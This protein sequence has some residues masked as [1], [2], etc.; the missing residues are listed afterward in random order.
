MIVLKCKM[1]GGN[2][3]V[4]EAGSV[5]TCPAC[6]AYQTVTQTPKLASQILFNRACELRIKGDFERAEA[7]YKRLAAED[8]T[9]AEAY[10]GIVLSKYGVVYQKNQ[11]NGNWLPMVQKTNETS[12]YTDADYCAAIERADA[13]KKACYEREAW[14][15]DCQEKNLLGEV[16]T[17]APCDVFLLCKTSDDGVGQW[18]RDRGLANRI[19]QNLIDAGLQVYYAPAYEAKGQRVPTEPFVYGS[20]KQAKVMLVVG[21]IPAN[22]NTP[23]VR[24]I[25]HR[26][27][28][29]AEADAMKRL[30]PCYAEMDKEHLPE[31][32]TCLT[33]FDLGGDAVKN[34]AVQ[35]K[36]AME[37]DNM[38]VPPLQTTVMMLPRLISRAYRFASQEAYMKAN[39]CATHM[40]DI[41]SECADAYVVKLLVDMRCK[42]KS[43][44]A[45]KETA[46][47]NNPNF[48]AAV[49][50]ANEDLKCE[51]EEY[52]KTVLARIREEAAR[53]SEGHYC[54]AVA[55]M[56]AGQLGEAIAAFRKAGEHYR[57]TK[58]QI[59][60]CEKELKQQRRR[61]RRKVTLIT[62]ITSGA[63]VLTATLII[64]TVML[65]VPLGRRSS[66][67]QMIADGNYSEAKETLR[68]LGDFGTAQT[69]LTVLEAFD[70]FKYE[71]ETETAIR[72][73]LDTGVPVT[74]AYHTGGGT[75]ST[76][77]TSDVPHADANIR[78]LSASSSD[79]KEF[80]YESLSEFRALATVSRSGYHFEK[81]ELSTYKY[82]PG[83]GG[84]V[85][86]TLTA[87]WTANT[88]GIFYHLNG[89]SVTNNPVEYNANTQTFTLNN[90]TRLGYTFVGWT[91]TGITAPTMQV[92]VEKGSY[93]ERNYTAVWRANT[94]TVN[95][96]PAGGTIAT[97]TVTVTFEKAFTLPTPTYAGYRFLGWYQGDEKLEEDVWTI[98][99]VVTLTARWKAINYTITYYLGNGVATNPRKFTI[100]T[101]PFTLNNPVREGYEFVG[102]TGNGIT[103]PT[104][105]MTVTVDKANP[106]N[107]EFTA[108]WRAKTYTITLNANGGD[109]VSA[110][111]E[112]TYAG[113]LEL[114]TPVYR[115]HKFLGWYEGTQKITDS[116]YVFSRD[117]E[118]QAMWEVEAYAITYEM[119]GG[120]N[121]AD[122]PKTYTVFDAVTLLAPPVRT[123][124]TFV[125]WTCNGSA[126]PVLHYTIPKGSTGAYDIVAHWTANTYTVTYDACGGSV[127]PTTVTFTYD[128]QYS[129]PTLTRSGYTFIGW[130]SAKQGGT[131][132]SGGTWKTADN[133]TLYA[134][135]SAKVYKV[136]FAACE[137][138]IYTITLNMNYSGS[139][140]QTMTLAAGETLA[141]PKVPTR[142]RYV[143][144]GWYTDSDCM[145]PYSFDGV[146]DKDITLYAKWVAHS[147]SYTDG[148][149]A[150]TSETIQKSIYFDMV[151]KYYA[152]V[153]LTD[154]T[155]S[156]S[157][158]TGYDTNGGLYDASMQ[159]LVSGDNG[160]YDFL[161]SYSLKAGELY[162]IGVV[163]K[164]N[165]GRNG[166]LHINLSAAPVFSVVGAG[167]IGAMTWN[168]AKQ[169]QTTYTYDE[170]F[171]LPTIKRE[172]YT[173]L[174]WYY[175]DT[176]VE[177]DVWKITSD[178]TLTAKWRQI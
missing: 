21:T 30:I 124:Y 112:V 173:F 13:D 102:W 14:S 17:A 84:A 123:G 131:R 139:T 79:L 111:M 58:A 149:I 73:I 45:L 1:C 150:L 168:I 174:G 39:E 119:G 38:V 35:V 42:D 155:I 76:S 16:A 31:E 154:C 144:G 158:N 51:L 33:P 82:T 2:M 44:L 117:I 142:S 8:A 49:R 159:P 137:K 178:V 108:H 89:G 24:Q 67:Y 74:I 175:G 59:E 70:Y 37:Q 147:A 136:T 165:Y 169:Y 94:Y 19:Y 90:P 126:T 56:E 50:F 32:L 47:E 146:I 118:L 60:A 85:T 69:D 152:I 77:A 134:Q 129:V 162:Y 156:V 97:N 46:P 15:I 145:T 167:Q 120:S 127:S 103:E 153:P 92:T 65:F 81:W 61:K 98:P 107:I 57:D 161:F 135:W 72:A 166:T 71:E 54:A 20:M 18:S 7:I 34:I 140:N 151:W 41:D 64:L 116:I 132:Y 9:D 80:T 93:G 28:K 106:H 164:G 26:Y 115:G 130:Y 23:E 27:L 91:G 6:H 12:I 66:A 62:L 114:P 121:H 5:T 160:T 83:E 10:W 78:V 133:I 53:I 141:Y 99:Q 177:G 63:T 29:M 105:F 11:Q 22:F 109:G 95:L 88:Y 100:T 68:D 163:A 113:A 87:E 172:G 176:K 125:G 148:A 4:S 104:T 40:L 3:T 96:L 75:L 171:A 48:W 128:A 25:W 110:N 52:N 86:L 170:A 43:E 101:A 122:N 143:F 138:L 157:A 55:A 36:A